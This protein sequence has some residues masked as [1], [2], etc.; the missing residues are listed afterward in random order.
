MAAG[1]TAPLINLDKLSKD[2]LVGLWY[3]TANEI[4]HTNPKTEYSK[5]A[6]LQSQ[7]NAIV[8]AYYKDWDGIV[9][10]EETA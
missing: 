8:E 1:K 10:L 5:W 2:E 3:D 9:R 6:L 7:F 4:S